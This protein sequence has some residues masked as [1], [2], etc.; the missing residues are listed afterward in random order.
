VEVQRLV[1]TSAGLSSGVGEACSWHRSQAAGLA[2]LII[3]G[4]EC[5]ACFVLDSVGPK[6][7]IPGP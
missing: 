4:G 1:V 3:Y 5:A 7:A 2:A 6:D